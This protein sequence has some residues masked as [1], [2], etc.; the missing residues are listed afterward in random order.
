[1]QQWN[2]C[3][4]EHS[5]R[6]NL[7]THQS[8]IQFVSNVSGLW[9]SGCNQHGL[10]IR[11]SSVWSTSEVSSLSTGGT[12]ASASAVAA[13]MPLI[14]LQ[15]QCALKHAEELYWNWYIVKKPTQCLRLGACTAECVQSAGMMRVFPVQLKY[16]SA[17]HSLHHTFNI[18]EYS[19][20]GNAKDKHSPLRWVRSLEDQQ[21][22][23]T[24][25]SMFLNAKNLWI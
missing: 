12:Y 9:Y 15:L 7:H 16:Q 24:N 13:S 22:E 10:T 14:N 18:T 21:Q 25:H 5:F 8:I 17:V 23:S 3:M 6:D 11:A 1:M 2:R 20:D 4:Y 19:I